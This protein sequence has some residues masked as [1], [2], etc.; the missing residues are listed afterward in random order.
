MTQERQEDAQVSA[1]FGMQSETDNR[2]REGAQVSARN[3]RA[4]V[5][6]IT[7]SDKDAQVRCASSEGIACFPDRNSRIRLSNNVAGLRPRGTE[8]RAP[9]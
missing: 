7:E 9:L 2:R 5:T 3:L 4:S 6:R 8:T 1:Q